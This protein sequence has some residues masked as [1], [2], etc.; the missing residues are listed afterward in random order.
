MSMSPA[1]L[2]FGSLFSILTPARN[3]FANPLV[4]SAQDV[5]IETVQPDQT[6]NHSGSPVNRLSVAGQRANAKRK[7]G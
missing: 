6:I 7:E 3:L 1:A 4:G 5:E 2:R